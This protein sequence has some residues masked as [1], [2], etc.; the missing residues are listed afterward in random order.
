MATDKKRLTATTPDGILTRTT[1]AAYQFVV[2]VTGETAACREE[3]RQAQVA[4]LRTAIKSFENRIAGRAWSY[5]HCNR[6]RRG[7]ARSPWFFRLSELPAQLQTLRQE[8]AAKSAAPITQPRLFAA[9][10]VTWASRRDLADKAAA[11]FGGESDQVK[12]YPVN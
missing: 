9:P 7:F 8:L 6:Y 3:R 5:P 10:E 2:V 11:R 1:A 12:V 4:D